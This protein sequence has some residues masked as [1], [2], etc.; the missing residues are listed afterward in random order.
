[1]AIPGSVSATIGYS[2]ETCL[3]DTR[4]LHEIIR[5]VN[6]AGVDAEELT[7][8][9]SEQNN[10]L[11]GN[12]PPGLQGAN[13]THAEPYGGVVGDISAAV[14]HLERTLSELRDEVVRISQIA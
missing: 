1:M 3:P 14:S 11:F 4:F 10:R 6:C 5:R 8:T 13:N 12:L 2:G 9:L 7:L